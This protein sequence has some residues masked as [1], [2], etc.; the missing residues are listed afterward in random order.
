MAVKW[1]PVLFTPPML[2]G[3]HLEN[4][5]DDNQKDKDFEW[6]H[7]MA[8]VKNSHIRQLD[9]LRIPLDLRQT[10]SYLIRSQQIRVEALTS[11]L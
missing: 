1:L 6:G 10:L 9:L 7:G 5:V 2:D 8:P 3:P 4:E 11:P